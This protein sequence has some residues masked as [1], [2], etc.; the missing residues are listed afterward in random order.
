MTILPIRR[1]LISVSDKSGLDQLAPLL[2]QHNIDVISSG[3][4]AKALQ[5]LGVTVI[6]IQDVTGNPEAFGGRMKTL[7]F[8]VSSALLYRRGH[9]GDEA[10]AKELNIQ[11]IDL[12]ICNLYP[13][14]DVVA[15][16]GDFL[17]KI[18]NIDIGGPTM[19]RA[20]AKN[21]DSVC[22]VVSPNRYADLIE[23]W[24]AHGGTRHNFRK[25][26][27][28]EAFRHTALY[29]SHIAKAFE[30]EVLGQSQSV[31]LDV[32]NAKTLRY[33][34]NPH[35]QAWLVPA[36]HGIASTPPLQGR[37][38][39][40]NNMLDADAAYR[41]CAD[42]A[43][44]APSRHAVTII[45]HLNP[46][47]AAIAD[48]QQEALSAAWAGD[49][50]SAFGSIICFNHS[51]ERESAEWLRKRFI[52]VIIAPSFTEE[53]MALFSKRKKLRLLAL[54]IEVPTEPIL[55]SIFGGHLIQGE[56]IGADTELQWVTTG[57]SQPND[58]LSQFG[59]YITKHLKSNAIS[60]VHQ[61]G[62]TLQL[63]GA[64]MGNPNRLISTQQ[65]IEKARENGMND[66]S[67]CILVSDAFFPFRDNVDLA[68]ESGIAC[69]IQPGGSIRDKEV[70]AACEEHN[71]A[72]GLTG[73]RHFRH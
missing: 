57:M 34:E 33:G 27:A 38:L 10:Q 72:M 46:C 48:T 26:R 41:S 2:I 61:T 71:I 70:R 42:I 6:P 22:V 36:G 60:L 65:A 55:R 37:A 31:A 43:Q 40:Y 29:D 73:R 14:A 67:S 19:V 54:D 51:V 24:N 4:T 52:E 5:N 11:P 50:I 53:A 69:I 58:T 35:Q 62:N 66:L 44:I 13:F 30:E 3:G 68:A 56:D 17:E 59:I 25:Q 45:K 64:G 28:L 1:A 39:S 32:A 8:A 21:H 20:A 12:V 7:S 47:G 16:G 49:P 15:R 9:E 63:I 18:E 23:E